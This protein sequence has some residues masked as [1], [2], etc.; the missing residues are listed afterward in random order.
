MGLVV[1]NDAGYLI[2]KDAYYRLDMAADSGT[3]HRI[4][5]DP[6]T[7]SDSTRQAL[8]HSQSS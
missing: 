4:F 2:E 1:V 8:D 3:Q 7:A 5:E 6:W